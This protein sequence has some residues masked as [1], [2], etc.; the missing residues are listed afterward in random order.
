MRESYGMTVCDTLEEMVDP[1][2]VAVLAID[3]QND[4]CSPEGHF[5][6]NGRDIEMIRERLPTMRRFVVEARKL[7]L[8]WSEGQLLDAEGRTVNDRDVLAALFDGTRS[9]G[10]S[11]SSGSRSRSA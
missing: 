5:A 3:I 10:R 8:Q 4:F 11:L 7:G 9:A 6:K 2:R 1:R